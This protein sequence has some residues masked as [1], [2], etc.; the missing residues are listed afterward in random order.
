ERDERPGRGQRKEP[1]LVERQ[2]LTSSPEFVQIRR[3]PVRIFLLHDIQSFASA[4]AGEPVGANTAPARHHRGAHQSVVK[5]GRYHRGFPIP[6]GA[7]NDELSLVDGAIRFQV[8]GNPGGAPCPTGEDPPIV[9]GVGGIKARIS[10]CPTT[11][12]IAQ[13]GVLSAIV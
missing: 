1:V 13:S 4:W 2:F 3:K 11:V 10:E 7:G 9:A 12:W 6:R 5:R 8:V